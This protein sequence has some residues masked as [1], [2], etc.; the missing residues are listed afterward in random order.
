MGK[1]KNNLHMVFTGIAFISLL[2]IILSYKDEKK[3]VHDIHVSQTKINPSE[4]DINTAAILNKKD[5]LGSPCPLISACLFGIAE[6]FYY[7]A[8]TNFK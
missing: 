5:P 7:I 4:T 6:S 1:Q 3:S 8:G 2:L